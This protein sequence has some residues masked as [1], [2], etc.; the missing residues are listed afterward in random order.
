MPKGM[1]SGGLKRNGR[2]VTP[3]TFRKTT[4]EDVDRIVQQLLRTFEAGDIPIDRT[5]LK[6]IGKVATAGML[7]EIRAEQKAEREE[8]QVQKVKERASERR[9]AS[10]DGDGGGA[11][12]GGGTSSTSKAQ[13][14]RR[15][16]KATGTGSRRSSTNF[17]E[18]NK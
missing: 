9:K 12:G 8:Q 4:S 18:V 5:A 3:G 16:R 7:E 11:G 1:I 14:S 6:V 2:R 15:K 13:R 10:I 17:D